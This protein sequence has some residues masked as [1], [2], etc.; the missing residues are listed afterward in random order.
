MS[1]VA[2]DLESQL[3]KLHKKNKTQLVMLS[4][5]ATTILVMGVMVCLMYALLVQSIDQTIAQTSQFE[6]CKKQP[7]ARSCDRPVTQDSDV[8]QVAGVRARTGANK[9]SQGVPGQPGPR[10]ER[11]E[12]G[13]GGKPGP[14]GT[15]GVNGV[16]GDDGEEG[17]QGDPGDPGAP[18]QTG[19]QGPPGKDGAAGA[20]GPKGDE[21]PKG[22]RGEQGPAGPAGP[23]GPKG[24]KGDKGDKGERGDT[25]P[26]G[27][28]G[29]LPTTLTFQLNGTEYT[30]TRQGD[31]YYTCNGGGA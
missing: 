20:Q 24:D 7:D 28:T 3:A 21:G 6:K 17:V 8:P 4:A 26:K 16:D 23:Q 1:N 10:G 5:S 19:A 27:D 30:C 25:G 14:A 13:W 2:K 9:G 12:R 29:T 15:P 22:S 18:G 31:N 11:G